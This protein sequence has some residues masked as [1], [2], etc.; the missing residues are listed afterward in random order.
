MK[1]GSFYL[2]MHGIANS[3]ESDCTEVCANCTRTIW[4]K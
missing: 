3:S 4:E 2:Q 1:L